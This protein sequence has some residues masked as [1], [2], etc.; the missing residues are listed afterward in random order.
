M[1]NYKGKFAIVLCGSLLF[2]KPAQALIYLDLT[3][4]PTGVIPQVTQAADALSNV[5][6]QLS[7]M[8]NNLKAIGNVKQTIAQYGKDLYN[9]GMQYAAN[10][11]VETIN[12]TLETSVIAQDELNKTTD[13]V[14][15]AQKV[16]A[17]VLVKQIES[18]MKLARNHFTESTQLAYNQN[19][20]P[21]IEEEEEEN[22]DIKQMQKGLIVV[23]ENIKKE[24]SQLSLELNDV[25]DEA[26]SIMNRGA[27]LNNKALAELLK[28]VD[29]SG[30]KL[31]E[32][33]R[34]AIQ[35]KLRDLISREQK[36]S[37]T[38]IE[39]AEQNQTRYNKEYQEKMAEG[40]NNY[41]NAVL[42]YTEGNITKEEV[43]KA[44]A[45][46]KNNVASIDVSS[47][48][49]QWLSYKQEITA[50]QKETAELAKEI[51]RILDKDA[52]N[53]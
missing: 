43:L 41:Q 45:L 18:G 21:L 44:G 8:T 19:N 23:F 9:K 15:S 38:G 2:M 26:I 25:Y 4:Y 53:S 32:E 12:N 29:T 30:N 51:S 24:S 11:A 5:K 16:F 39:I 49:E 10:N 27:D 33:Q 42:A 1:I 3:E 48:K 28:K 47:N 7:E 6:S 36:I 20:F 17:E 31:S 40:I 50:V 52:E 13:K 46:F 35:T 37:D 14:D 22:I 34:V